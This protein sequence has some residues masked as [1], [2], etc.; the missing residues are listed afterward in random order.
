MVDRIEPNHEEGGGNSSLKRSKK[1]KKE[2]KDEQQK[3]KRKE[4]EQQQQK[5][6]KKKKRKKKTTNMNDVSLKK[7]TTNNKDFS[8]KSH[9]CTTNNKYLDDDLVVTQILTRLPAKSLMRFK[10]VCK[11]WKS[12]IEQDSHFIN[13]HY[14]HSQARPPQ[15]LT[16][17]FDRPNSSEGRRGCFDL[18]SADLDCDGGDG[19]VR[20]AT[21][22][23]S[24]ITLRSPSS[25]VK[26]LG[27][28]RG[29]LCFADLANFDV[30][31]YNVSTRQAVTPWIRSSVSLKKLPFFK[32]VC[33][34]GFDLDT[35]EHKVIFVWHD[36]EPE[37]SRVPACC[38]VLTVGVDASWRIID[39]IPTHFFDH[40]D[41]TYVN[42]SVYWVTIPNDSLLEFDMGSEK[43]RIIRIPRFV[44][45]GKLMELGGCLT[46]VP[47][48]SLGL[49][50]KTLWT[51]H[52]RNKKCSVSRSEGEEWTQFSFELP[53][54]IFPW[55]AKL[56]QIPGKD[57]IV[58]ETYTPDHKFCHNVKIAGFFCYNKINNNLSE[59]RIRRIPSL[60]EPSNT[61]SKLFVESLFH[62]AQKRPVKNPNKS[63]NYK[64]DFAA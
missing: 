38:E 64:E 20:G 14:T 19:Y 6:K 49:R 48:R 52:G 2:H 61:R 54:D 40:I 36:S 27:P 53:R 45:P 37:E 33:E 4:D 31:I 34:F 10:S 11:S 43:F 58:L 42:G 59:F 16:I 29:L 13:L 55:N 56:H 23:S 26:V 9:V 57:H 50:I 30:M 22:Q 28:V 12:I 15:L 32:P 24:A 63:C 18:L 3:K 21:I 25:M 60:P 41:C 46:L 7:R 1:R 8:L 44:P 35:G 39:A 47:Y 51:F 5:K 62:A 17:V